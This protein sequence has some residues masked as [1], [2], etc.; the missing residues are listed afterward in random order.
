VPNQPDFVMVVVPADIR[1]FHLEGRYNYESLR[2]GSLFVGVNAGTGD[3]LRLDVTGMFGGVFGIST[4][5]P[6]DSGSR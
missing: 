5:W 1:W 3:K 2:T 4:A 6:P